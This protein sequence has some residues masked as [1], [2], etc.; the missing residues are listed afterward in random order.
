MNTVNRQEGKPPFLHTLWFSI[1]DRHV[2]VR[3]EDATLWSLLVTNYRHLQPSHANR[4]PADLHYTVGRHNTA[5]SFFIT[6]A[7]EDQLV[8]SDEDEFL[9]LFEKEMTIALQKL[10][11]DLYFIHAAVLAFAGKAVMLVAPSGS[12]K[13]TTTWALLHHGFHYL[14]DELG[15]VDLKTLTVFPYPRALCLKAAPPSAYPLPPSTLYTTS[16]LHIPT[17]VLPGLVYRDP[18]PLTAIFFLRYHPQA[19]EPTIRPLS[20]AKATAHLWA[21]ALNPLAH[22]EDGFGGALTLAT[23]SACFALFTAALPVTCALITATLEGLL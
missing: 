7:G 22:P 10:R 1:C 11:H 2:Q 5:S 9:F 4:T 23:R 3:C 18:L 15:P 8:A 6:R 16:T 20:K 17:D 14:S 13:S 21:N 19:A 12:G